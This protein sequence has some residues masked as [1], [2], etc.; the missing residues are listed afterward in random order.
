M[1]VSTDLNTLQVASKLETRTIPQSAISSSDCSDSRRTLRGN[2]GVSNGSGKERPRKRLAYITRLP[3][4]L[5]RAL[6][7]LPYS[8]PSS[9]ASRSDVRSETTTLVDEP[10]SPTSSISSER[11]VCNAPDRH[12]RDLLIIFFQKQVKVRRIMPVTPI[13]PILRRTTYLDRRALITCSA[14]NRRNSSASLSTPTSSPSLTYIPPGLLNRH[15]LQGL[16]YEDLALLPWP[17]R[18]T[19]KKPVETTAR[20]ATASRIAEGDPSAVALSPQ[21]RVADEH[22]EDEGGPSSWW[23]SIFLFVMFQTGLAVLTTLILFCAF[24]RIVTLGRV[25]FD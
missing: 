22:P 23:P 3:K 25:R 13:K 5:W 2:T 8:T 1:L 6:R 18:G 19:P 21:H 20:L 15:S 9:S 7:V 14:R 24:L 17:S 12:T 4:Q 10:S 16:E 11:R